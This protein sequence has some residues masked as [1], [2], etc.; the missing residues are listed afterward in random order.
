M[1]NNLEWLHEFVINIFKNVRSLHA[2]S[3]ILHHTLFIC[4]SRWVTL[5]FLNVTCRNKVTF[6]KINLLNLKIVENKQ[7]IMIWTNV[8]NFE[9]NIFSLILSWHVCRYMWT[10]NLVVLVL[11]TQTNFNWFKQHIILKNGKN[12]S[13]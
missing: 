13:L 4:V 1:S 7:M 5:L 8:R 10:K 6:R 9:K 11:F 12:M 2:E 3:M